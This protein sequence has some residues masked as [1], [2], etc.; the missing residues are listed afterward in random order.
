M[1]SLKLMAT[2]FAMLLEQGLLIPAAQRVEYKRTRSGHW[3]LYVVPASNTS[4][5]HIAPVMELVDGTG[6]TCN[7]FGAGG[8]ITGVTF[9]S[10]EEQADPNAEPVKA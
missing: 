9:V 8:K 4:P 6:V 10:D 1:H 5:K 7:P 2:V 3:R